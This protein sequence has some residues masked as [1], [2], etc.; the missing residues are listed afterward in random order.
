MVV[1]NAESIINQA[2]KEK[3]L[4]LDANSV[5]NKS[6]KNGERKIKNGKL[7]IEDTDDEDNHE[8]KFSKRVVEDV[9]TDDE[10]NLMKEVM[11][12]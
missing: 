8:T 10:D 3:M 12:S 11:T 2:K 4:E 9:E 1:N 6:R 5:E 7:A